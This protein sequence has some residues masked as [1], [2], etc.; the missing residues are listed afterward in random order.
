[1]H[2]TDTFKGNFD[3]D[4]WNKSKKP[5]LETLKKYSKIPECT[6]WSEV[7]DKKHTF[8]THQVYQNMTVDLSELADSQNLRPFAMG[9]IHIFDVTPEGITEISN[10]N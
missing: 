9:P 10:S 4:N 8:E 6:S 3:N 5:D 2:F 7:M 1:V